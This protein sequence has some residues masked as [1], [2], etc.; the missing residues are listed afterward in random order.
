[1][2]MFLSWGNWEGQGE[3]RVLAGCW[4]KYGLRFGRCGRRVERREDPEL[5]AEGGWLL[6]ALGCSGRGTGLLVRTWRRI[7]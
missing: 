4:E 1:V 5:G 3:R 2:S 7:L 6:G